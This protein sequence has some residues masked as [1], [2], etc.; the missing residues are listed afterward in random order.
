MNNTANMNGRGRVRTCF[1]LAVIAVLAFF[2]P[3]AQ[4]Q[5]RVRVSVKFI[6]GSSGQ[7]PSV[8]GGGFGSSSYALTSDS[9]V[10]SNI[11]YANELLTQ[12]GRG[13]Q[14]QLTEI[15]DVSGWS[16]F[17]SI[18]ARDQ[19]NKEDLEAVATSNATTRAQFF[20]RSDA[21]NIYINNS[22]SGYCS[23]PG[24][25]TII[26]AGSQAYDTLL[27]HEMGHYM[28]LAHTH[29]GEQFRDS[30]NSSCSAA[31]CSCA[32]L[33]AGTSDGFADTLPDVDCW[34]RSQMVAANPGATTTQIDNTFLN[35]MSY[36][37][38]QDRFTSDQFDAWTDAANSP[39]FSVLTGRTRFVATSGNDTTGTGTSA[40]RFRTLDKGVTTANS[41]D[42]VLLRAGS[43]NETATITK[44]VTLRATR[45]TVVIGQ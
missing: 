36:H 12:M 34:T 11:N 15:Q 9:A 27:I 20:Y 32:I 29:A 2:E 22:S 7:R 26:F 13:Y 39:R 4:A 10:I 6:L 37:L 41:G 1:L 42:I 5:L 35:I 19:G 28:S 17:F 38:P 24:G 25:G 14:Y 3:A 40:S 45:G 23:F 31:N 21:I 8:G 33:I 16:G 43:Y 30:D 18:S 44:A